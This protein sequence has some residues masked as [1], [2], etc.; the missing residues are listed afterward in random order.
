MSRRASGFRA[1]ALQRFT[2]IYLGLFSILL[3]GV[4]MFAPPPDFDTWRA[5]A[6]DP[7]ISVLSLLFLLALLLHAWVG[8]RDVII[9]YV[10]H[11]GARL[12]LLSLFAVGIAMTGI[13]A[14]RVL[15]LAAIGE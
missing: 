4:F 3:L 9:D 1:W 8:I 2:A 6:A 13:W 5:W 12:T 11:S 7:V 15:L 10:W 14:A